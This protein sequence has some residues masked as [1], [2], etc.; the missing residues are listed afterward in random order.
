M[1]FRLLEYFLAVCE[2]LH[3]TKAAERLGISQPTLSQQIRL[4]EERVGTPL[5]R[6]IGKKNYLTEAGHTLKIHALRILHE[7]EQAQTEINEIRGLQRGKLRIGCSGNHLLTTTIVSFHE[8]Y[9]GIE[10]TVVELATEETR[11]G[12]LNNK[13][14]IGV[15]F[16]PL[17]DEQLTSQSLY[18]EELCL[19]VSN[20]HPLGGEQHIALSRLQG[21]PLVLFPD[22]FLVRQMIDGY[23]DQDGI[24]LK[25]ILELS[26]MD[27]MLQM[28]RL[29]IGGTILPRS[30]M[31]HVESDHF[32][33]ISIIEPVPHKEVGV[34]YRKETYMRSALDAFIG[35]LI[36]NLCQNRQD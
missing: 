24:T 12:L 7:L 16:L 26:T 21:L 18:M 6:R 14:D 20:S 8:K 5:F 32:K 25:P 27:A 19:V 17:E 9:P 15:V 31:Q 11:Q 23:C 34:V 29:N 4:L 1:E 2:E 36:H 33:I 35:E 3:F 10:L 22:K 13:L 30:F 28:V